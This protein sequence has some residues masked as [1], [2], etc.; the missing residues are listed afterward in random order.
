MSRFS[1]FGRREYEYHLKTFRVWTK[2]IVTNSP[3]Y[4]LTIRD[5]SVSIKPGPLHVISD[6]SCHC[7]L[8]VFE[9]FTFKLFLY[10]LITAISFDLARIIIRPA[11]NPADIQTRRKEI[12]EPPPEM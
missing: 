6:T 7:P 9:S 4:G 5:I 1:I 2:K 8:L 10:E 3:I 12:L 11:V